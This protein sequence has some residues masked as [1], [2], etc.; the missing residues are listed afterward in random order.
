MHFDLNNTAW[1]YSVLIKKQN[2]TSY[3]LIVDN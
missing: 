1:D 2:K 3:K